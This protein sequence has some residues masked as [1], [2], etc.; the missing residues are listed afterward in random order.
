VPL[1]QAGRSILA[2]APSVRLAAGQTVLLDPAAR[3]CGGGLEILAGIARVFCPFEG[4]GGITIAFL[5]PG[6]HLFLA[7]VYSNGVCLEALT[8]LAFLPCEH[9]MPNDCPD[10]VNEWVLQLLLI[11]HLGS[12]EKRL[13]ALLSLLVTRMGHRRG[14]WCDLPFRLSHQRISEIIGTTRATTTRL[15]SRLRASRLLVSTKAEPIVRLSPELL[16]QAPLAA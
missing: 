16:I 10:V 1:D 8:P 9:E 14:P 5:Q 4:T 13:Q 6:D 11:R 7:R 12:A 3:T 2:E 15:I